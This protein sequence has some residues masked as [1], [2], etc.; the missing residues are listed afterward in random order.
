MQERASCS[1][2]SQL[3][4][5]SPMTDYYEYSCLHPP[6]LTPHQVQ[7]PQPHNCVRF[8]AIVDRCSILDCRGLQD[9]PD[10]H[11]DDGGQDQSVFEESTIYRLA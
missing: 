4:I 1:Q 2:L 5:P 8:T 7:S 3:N 9:I 6:P 10:T 11:G